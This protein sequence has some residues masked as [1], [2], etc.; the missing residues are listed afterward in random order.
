MPNP[1]VSVVIPL[2]NGQRYIAETLQSVLAQTFSDIE[3][4]IIDDGSTDQSIPICKRF[5][6]QRIRYF[7]QSNRGLAGARNTGIRFARGEYIAFIDADDLWSP[8]KL[9][10]HVQ[11]FRFLPKMGVSYSYSALINES[12]QALGV[13]L[14]SGRSPTTASHCFIRNP[15]G[16]GS[17]AVIRANVLKG[18][19]RSNSE[20]DTDL[21]IF[22]EELRQAE[23]LELW[24]RIAATSNWEFHCIPAPLTLYRI[25]STG[26]SSDVQSQRNYHFLALKKINA[27]APDLIAK[28]G[29][30]NLSIF[31]WYLARTSIIHG[32]LKEGKRHIILACKHALTTIGFSELLVVAAAVFSSVIPFRYFSYGQSVVL[33]VYG[34]AQRMIIHFRQRS[35]CFMRWY[36]T[37]VT[38]GTI[39]SETNY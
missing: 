17:N 32:S 1:T 24:V 9:E 21:F 4:L 30:K 20:E 16:N 33:P 13:F 23:D 18:S 25:N 31:Y 14:L 12:G 2:Y 29:K 19:N 11:H 27:Y 10:M 39:A 34:L 6:D 26:L 22:D 38:S 3:V 37:Q 7:H 36:L 15:I 8:E 35:S 5:T 28:Y